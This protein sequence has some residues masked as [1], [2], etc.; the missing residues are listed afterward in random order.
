MDK[1]NDTKTQ[2]VTQD[3]KE[4]FVPEQSPRTF[5]DL[6]FDFQSQRGLTL[7][8]LSGTVRVSGNS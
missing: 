2:G 7:Q 4:F 8:G 6:V 1:D 3:D 5:D